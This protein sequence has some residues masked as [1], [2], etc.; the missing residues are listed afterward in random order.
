[1]A[2]CKVK[3]SDDIIINVLGGEIACC[4]IYGRTHIAPGGREGWLQGSTLIWDPTTKD[5]DLGWSDPPHLPCLNTYTFK[6]P[7]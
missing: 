1:M 2:H 4:F 3:S 6:D 5:L 7:S